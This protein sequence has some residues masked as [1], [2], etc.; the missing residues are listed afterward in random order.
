MLIYMLKAT[1]S[2]INVFKRSPNS[3]ISLLIVLSDSC[4]E[5]C[6]QRP[7]RVLNSPIPMEKPVNSKAL[8]AGQ[9]ITARQTAARSLRSSRAEDAASLGASFS[10][11]R[12]R[13]SVSTNVLYCPFTLVAYRTVWCGR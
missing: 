5:D 8:C 12:D 4:N 7:T 10:S 13:L 6:L 11:V 1:R 9:S 3:P 2:F